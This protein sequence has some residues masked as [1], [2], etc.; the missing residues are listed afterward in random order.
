M[1]G[2]AGGWTGGTWG[3]KLGMSDLY[4]VLVAMRPKSPKSWLL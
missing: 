2:A 4:L 3:S 1:V